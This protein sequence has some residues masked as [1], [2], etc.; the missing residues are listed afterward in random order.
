M[1]YQIEIERSALKTLQIIPS[2]DRNKLIDAIEK[3]ARN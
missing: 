3:L 2:K 1:K